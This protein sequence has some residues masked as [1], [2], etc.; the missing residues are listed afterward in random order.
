MTTL[1][2]PRFSFRF[3][4]PCQFREPLW[5][6]Q[7]PG[8]E[9]AHRLP[10]LAS[11]DSGRGQ[12]D[13]RAAWSEAGLAVAVR[14]E[15]KR[16]APWCR[17]ARPEDSD[18]V[19][20]WVD[21]RDTKNIHRAGRFCHQFVFMP[22]GSGRGLDEPVAEPLLIHRAREHPKPVRPGV[23]QVR[24]EKRVDGYVIEALIPAAALTGFD[25]AENPR[26][27]FM[28]AILDRELGEQAWCCPPQFPYRE[29]PSL[30]G[31]LE[32]VRP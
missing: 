27:G 24:R 31:T 30:W 2:P 4:V 26:L 23:L 20:I 21:T 17:D 10:D 14:V 6:A 16:Q 19:R 8:L 12:L 29:D 3:A 11:L 18:S 5:N 9:E 25:P 7:G 32:L 1:V 28:C 22:S 13:L 15:G